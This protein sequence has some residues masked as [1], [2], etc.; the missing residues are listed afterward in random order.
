MSSFFVIE[1]IN[2]VDQA[3]N[4]RGKKDD[5]PMLLVIHGG[6]GYA[7][8]DLFHDI[9]PGLEDHFV[10]VN[11][12]QRGAGLSYNQNVDPKSLTL[13]QLVDDAESIRRFVLEK[14][15]CEQ[16]Q[17]AYV[18]GHSMGTMLWLELVRKYKDLYKAYFGIGQVVNVVE[19]EQ[20]MYDWALAQAKERNITKAIKHL[21]CIGR[22]T[23]DFIYLF[24]GKGGRGCNPEKIDPY[25]VTMGWVEA[26]GGELFGKDGSEEVDKLILSSRLYKGKKRKWS[27]GL[28]FSD[29]LFND[30]LV[31]SW[32]ARSLCVELDTPVYLLMGRHDYDTPA[33]LAKSYFDEIKGPRKLIWF[34]RSSHFPFYEES[35]KF[36]AELVVIKNALESSTNS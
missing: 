30:P 36:V 20:V 15:G 28:K 24:P 23:D 6:P 18:L 33:P 35:D 9:L 13:N 27:Q 2:G 11:Y 4:V 21:D 32:N 22:P 7:M 29:N 31:I 25:D 3:I 1:P 10:V 26:F 19:N 16:N 14:L 8:I 17:P 5:L 34:E 12:D